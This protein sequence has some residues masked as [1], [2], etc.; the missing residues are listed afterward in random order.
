MKRPLF[1]MLD[2]Q[3]MIEDNSFYA[4]RLQYSIALVKLKREISR[5][6]ESIIKQLAKHL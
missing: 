4:D 5:I 3:I 6:L 1:D 2:R